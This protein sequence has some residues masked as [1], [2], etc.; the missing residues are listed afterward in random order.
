MILAKRGKSGGHAS[1]GGG[2]GG[3][4]S[5]KQQS[6][7]NPSNTNTNT[8]STK[9]HKKTEKVEEKL[10]IVFGEKLG[11]GNDQAKAIHAKYTEDSDY[12]AFLKGVEEL[13][14]PAVSS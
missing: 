6:T 10:L 5:H 12:A 13:C 4:H 2:G 11:E 9:P 1:S 3:G 8:A 14:S 7:G